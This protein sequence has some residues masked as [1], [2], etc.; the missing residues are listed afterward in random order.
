MSTIA[1]LTLDQY[2]LMIQSGAF[3]GQNQ[4]RVELI[5]GEL[6]AMSP[7]GSKHEVLVDLLNEWSMA[8]LPEKAVWVRVQNSVGIPELDSAPEPDIAWVARRS[9]AT[10]R[11][12]PVD[13]LLIIEVAESSLSYDRS[14]KAELYATAGLQDYWIVNIPQQCVEVHRQPD[15]GH[16]GRM[17]TFTGAD[18][19]HPLA[20]PNLT[21]QVETLFSPLPGD[22]VS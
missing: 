7:I 14:E 18:E 12:Q 22:D 17:Q 21:L 15:A 6:R 3:D 8:N 9:Y 5:H 20:F 2:D 4:R 11:P 16:Y 1:R 19:V 10:E 13:V